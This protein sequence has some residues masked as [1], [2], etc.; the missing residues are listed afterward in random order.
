MEVHV[1]N[2]HG[3]NCKYIEIPNTSAVEMPKSPFKRG[4]TKCSN[5]DAFY[6]NRSRP[7]TCFCG[8]NLLQKIEKPVLN[9][10]QL[11]KQLFS[12]RQHINGINKRVLVNTESRLCYSVNCL[13]NRSH[14]VDL[15]KFTCKHLEAC[16]DKNSYEVATLKELEVSTVERFIQCELTME[17]LRKQT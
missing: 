1:L 11:T 13:V 10:V 7:E 12:V 8:H 9:P 16:T 14:F 15:T 17:E 6:N 3:P 2:E 4:Q 5:C